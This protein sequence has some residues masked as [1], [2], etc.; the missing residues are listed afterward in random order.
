MLSE[1]DKGPKESGEWKTETE[2]KHE[3]M[4]YISKDTDPVY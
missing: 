2:T 4:R 3:N 1:S